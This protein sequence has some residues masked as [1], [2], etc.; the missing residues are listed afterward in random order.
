MVGWL[1]GS[2]RQRRLGGNSEFGTSR[3]GKEVKDGGV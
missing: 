1:E 3:R 2:R